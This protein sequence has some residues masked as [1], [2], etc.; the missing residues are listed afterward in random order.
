M[1]LKE[2]FDHLSY[3]ELSQLSIGGTEGIN[4]SNW[5][6][7]LS[8]VNRGLTELHK[9]F[10]L[11][12]GTLTLGMMAGTQRYVLDVKHAASNRESHGVPKY[13]L[14]SQADPFTGL[15][16]IERVYAQDG[17]ELMLNRGGDSFDLAQR[18][19]RTPTYKSLVLPPE[20]AVQELRVVYR[21]NHP[22]IVKEVGYFNLE[23]VSVELPDTHLEALL[24]YVASQL[25]NPTGVIGSQGQFHEGNNY[26]A[27]FEAACQ[28]LDDKDYRNLESE[29]NYR[30]L[31]N[32]WV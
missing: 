21:A 20:L 27:K 18:S 9:R 24:Y 10:L 7:V 14:D 15:M 8:S 5:E 23:E 2:I 4:E 12:E 17:T 26:W 19:V 16:K 22:K 3:G 13:I 31:R 30:L 25:M 32:G 29:E 6:R 1:N 28:Q 11:R